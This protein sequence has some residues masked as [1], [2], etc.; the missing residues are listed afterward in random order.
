M[1]AFAVG[2]GYT[3]RKGGEAVTV[4]ADVLFVVNFSL[5]YVSLYITGRLMSLPLSTRRLC[6]A[7]AVGACYAV[8]ALF[9]NPPELVYIA[10]NVL[11]SAIMCACAYDCGGTI[12]VLGAAVLL[13][14]VGCALGGAMTAVYSLGAGYTDSLGAGAEPTGSGV[15][16][17]AAAAAT[18][19]VTL[20]GRIAKKRRGIASADVTIT[21]GGKTATVTAL[22]D[23]GNL[24]RDPVSGR[25]ALV[26]SVPEAARVLPPEAVALTGGEDI[27]SEIENL[28]PEVRARVRLLPVSNV[29]GHGLLLGYR[30]DK[31][32]VAV[33]GGGREYDCVLA[34]STKSGGFGGFGAV[35]PAEIS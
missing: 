9:F 8:F 17:F 5:D 21:V 27:A 16:L 11:V 29:Y 32:T 25:A 35:L 26:L 14:A 22:A 15:I 34:V 30:P 6:A 7:A 31:V 1:S 23:S 33:R 3:F 20:G 2:V 24:L 18:A 28:P 13:F 19:A 12:R 4:Y 10:V